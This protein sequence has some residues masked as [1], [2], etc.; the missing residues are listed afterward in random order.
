MIKNDIS[1]CPEI[2]SRMR[3]KPKLSGRGLEILCKWKI[4]SLEMSDQTEPLEIYN[5]DPTPDDLTDNDGRPLLE[6]FVKV[7]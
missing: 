4:K 1:I 2:I 5:S 7:A 6:L 3:I